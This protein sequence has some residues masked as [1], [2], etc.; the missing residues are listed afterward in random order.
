M[1]KGGVNV[2]DKKLT[3]AEIY[4]LRYHIYRKAG[5]S[6]VEA[7]KMRSRKLDI[8]GLRLKNGEVPYK[9][10]TF[11]NIVNNIDYS[12]KIYSSKTSDKKLT[13]AEIYKLRYHIYRKA[14]YSAVEARKMRSR[15]LDV[16]DLRLKNGKVPYES[17][18]F[19]NIVN[20]IDYS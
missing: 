7:R 5:Y 19:Q 13:R 1:L 15:K 14:G 6:A 8:E 17:K 16:E 2:S 3:R 18:T 10:K 9:S 20:N 12:S 11:Q 4:K